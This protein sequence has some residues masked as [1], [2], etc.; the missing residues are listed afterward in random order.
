MQEK[1]SKVFMIGATFNCRGV[2]K[3]GMSKFLSDFISEHNV[4]FL[5]LQETIKT[6]YS[7]TFFKNIDPQGLFDWKW[8][9]STGRSGGILGGFRLSRFSITDTVVGKFFI[10]VTLLDLKLNLK[11]CLV[12]VYG[13]AQVGDK[14]DF[15]TEL[16]MVC[17]DQRLPLLIGGDFNIMRFSSEK[18]KGMR[19]NRWSDMFNSII[20]T[21]ALREINMSGGQYTWSN[22]QTVPTLE[23]LDRFLMSS[24]WEDLFPL[25]TVHKLN[26]DISDHNPLILDTMEGKPKKKYEFRFEKN[27]IKEEDFLVRV[28]RAWQQRVRATNSLDKLQKKLKN[29]KNCLKGWGHNLRGNYKK[30]KEDI[31]LLLT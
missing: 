10:K 25:T 17:N 1:K 5:G 3:K 26:R 30:R 2:G 7:S 20:N 11:W 13:A 4:D 27:W 18:N 8:I 23:K 28:D 24:S 21:Y 19:N 29:V 12:I 15:L 6:N 22:S 9:S 31:S 14:D 16:G